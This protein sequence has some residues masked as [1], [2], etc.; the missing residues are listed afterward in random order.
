MNDFKINI[1]SDI[2]N[3][4]QNKEIISKKKTMNIVD[5]CP[6]FSDIEKKCDDNKIIKFHYYEIN[7]LIYMLLNDPDEYRSMK[8]FT[9]KHY[10]IKN[11]LG[12]LLLECGTSISDYE[13]IFVKVI[14]TLNNFYDDEQNHIE[15]VQDYSDSTRANR[16]TFTEFKNIHP[17]LNKIHTMIDKKDI[18]ECNL[19][20]KLEKILNLART[21]H[22]EYLKRDSFF[23]EKHYDSKLLITELLRKYYISSVMIDDVIISFIKA[24]N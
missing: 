10:D 6:C 5:I 1:H 16:Y 13:S 2:D 4:V 11:N 7:R 20:M 19:I 3:V 18:F 14:D 12:K 9:E 8:L 23:D 24:C 15:I 17:V 21:N 22:K